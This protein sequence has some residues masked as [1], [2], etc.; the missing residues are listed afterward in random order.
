MQSAVQPIEPGFGDKPP[1][2]PVLVVDDEPEVRQVTRLVLA[3]AEFEG[4][5]LEILE[6]ASAEQASEILQHRPDIAVMLLDVVMETPHAGL[7][8]IRRVR[9]EL[10]NPFVRIVLRTG[11]PGEAPE[12][13]VVTS[14][15]INDYREKTEMTATRLMATLYT[16]LRSWRDLRTIEAQRQ[17]L[18]GVIG[19]SSRIFARHNA[20]GFA[21]A[22]MMQLSQLLG[23]EVEVFCV[24]LPD[25]AESESTPFRILNGIGRF[26][27]LRERDPAPLLPAHVLAAMRNAALDGNSNYDADVCVLHIAIANLTKRMLFVCLGRQFSELDRQLLWLFGTNADIAWDNLHLETDLLDAQQ[28][29]VFLLASTAETRSRE[30]ASHVHRVGLLVEILA[31]GLGLDDELCAMLRLAAPLHDIGKV[32]IPDTILNKPGS[33]T[34]EESRIM[35]THAAIGARLLGNS[36][37]PA[38]RLAAEIALTHHENWDGSGYPA[39]L[40]GE[41]IPVSGR[42]TMVA[43][44]FDALG[45]RR[46][47]K[48]PWQEAQ[49]RAY[50]E[51][52]RG[53]KLDPRI[54]DL[55]FKHWDQAIALRRQ[56][57]D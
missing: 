45:S 57:P 3:R 53:R 20:H 42:L 6:A 56:L 23:P 39:G 55:L 38:M 48:E 54:L 5:G 1:P 16:A 47:Y 36:Q 22:M 11:Q 13:N 49:I 9:E 50:L 10:R 14:Y 18:E 51:Q 33:H 44:V 40:A 21:H 17:G 25:H 32:G 4:R 8:L 27:N 7:D 30:T 43:D 2:W 46:C 26:R 31:R 24:A 52:E 29:M 35:H 41:A 12:L 28:E 37:R 15:D 19:A 34:P